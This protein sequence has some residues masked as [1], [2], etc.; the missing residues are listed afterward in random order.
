M[1]KDII[2]NWY[3]KTFA[4]RVEYILLYISNHTQHIEQRLILNYHQMYSLLFIDRYERDTKVISKTSGKFI[5]REEQ[6]C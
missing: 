5:L 4:E 3:P 6:A 1:D 2:E